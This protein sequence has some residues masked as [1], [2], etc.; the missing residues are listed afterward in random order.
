MTYSIPSDITKVDTDGDGKIDRIYVGDVDAQMWRFEITP[1]G[2]TGRR[3][4][5]SNAGLSEKRKIFYPPDVTFEEGYEMLFFGTGDRE[6]PKSNKDMDRIYAFK[7]M[8]DMAVLGEANLYD[9]TADLLQTGTAEQQEIEQDKLDAASGWYI[10]LDKQDGEKCLASPVVFYRTAYYTTF[11]PTVGAVDDPCFVG[12][13]EAWVYA[14]NYMN[15]N[16]VFNFDLSNDIGGVVLAKSDRI[17]KI[18]TAIP[19]GVIITV[20]GNTAVGYVGVGGGIFKPQL[21]KTKIFYPLHWK[22]VF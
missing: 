22:I 17:V 21:K 14:V 11:S 4:F 20:I 2:M 19:S 3:V 7:D 10:K 13:G 16:A 1:T 5:K 8:N 12:E 18:G 15:G 6:A 9:A